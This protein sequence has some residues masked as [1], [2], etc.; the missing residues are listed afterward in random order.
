M[1]SGIVP[2]VR[3]RSIGMALSEMTTGRVPWVLIK[4][5]WFIILREM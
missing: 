1:K 5:E 4:P 3:D 2:V